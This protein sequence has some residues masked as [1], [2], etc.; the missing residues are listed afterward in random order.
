MKKR[1]IIVI[2]VCLILAIIFTV[3][4]NTYKRYNDLKQIKWNEVLDYLNDNFNEPMEITDISIIDG[5]YARCNPI[6]NTNLKFTVVYWMN[7]NRYIDTYFQICLEN[8][9]KQLIEKQLMN[10]FYNFECYVQLFTDSP[11]KECVKLYDLYNK[12]GRPLSWHDDI[13]DESLAYVQLVIHDNNIN[14]DVAY[15]IIKS[16]D[17]LPVRYN[18]I[19]ISKNTSDNI[20]LEINK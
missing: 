12:L 4:L 17:K 1:T 9:A 8:E 7:E 16:I 6:D 2:L 5:C 18:R 20:I 13:C 10:S 3:L 11:F 14:G 19:I 15:G